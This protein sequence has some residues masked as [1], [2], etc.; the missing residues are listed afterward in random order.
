MTKEDLYTK[1][2]KYSFGKYENEL[3]D[4]ERQNIAQ[5][6]LRAG[7][8]FYWILFFFMILDGCFVII[9]IIFGASLDFHEPTAFWFGIF[10]Y[11]LGH[12]KN[13]NQFKKSVQ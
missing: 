10:G 11:L 12:W 3:S 6:Y 7:I 13:I 1:L 9:N 8:W 4:E 2:F 5:K